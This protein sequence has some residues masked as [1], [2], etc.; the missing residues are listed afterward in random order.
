MK[1]E[2]KK[3]YPIERFDFMSIE[4]KQLFKKQKLDKFC[5]WHKGNYMDEVNYLLSSFDSSVK[6]I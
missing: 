2:D 1:E 6:R 4:F 5:I 3:C